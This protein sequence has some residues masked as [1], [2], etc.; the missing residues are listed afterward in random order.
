MALP[1]VANRS[2]QAVTTPPPGVQKAADQFSKLAQQASRS[3][4]SANTT[5]SDGKNTGIKHDQSKV[6][7]RGERDQGG[8]GDQRDNHG[9]QRRIVNGVM[10]TT[11]GD[12]HVTRRRLGTDEPQVPAGPQNAGVKRPEIKQEVGLT[13]GYEQLR[14][15][16]QAFPTAGSVVFGLP[17][18]FD[19]RINPR[20]SETTSRTAS[21]ASSTGATYLQNSEA[22]ASGGDSSGGDGGRDG[23]QDGGDT[24]GD[25][26]GG[27]GGTI[28]PNGLAGG[29]DGPDGIDFEMLQKEV[30]QA[31][32]RE[33]S[34]LGL[35]AITSSQN[36]SAESGVQSALRQFFS[37]NPGAKIGAA[38][39]NSLNNIASMLPADGDTAETMLSFLRQL[40]ENN[41]KNKDWLESDLLRV[42]TSTEKL[43]QKQDPANRNADSLVGIANSLTA[44]PMT[45]PRLREISET[46]RSPDFSVPAFGN[47]A[48]INTFVDQIP[49]STGGDESYANAVASGAGQP[50]LDA[51]MRSMIKHFFGETPGAEFAGKILD[52]IF[53]LATTQPYNPAGSQAMLSMLRNIRENGTEKMYGLSSE[54]LSTIISIAEFFLAQLGSGQHRN[55]TVLDVLKDMAEQYN[56]DSEPEWLANMASQI[57]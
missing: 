43:V 46:L 47:P 44:P 14:N 33:R 13:A 6:Q 25:N 10:I 20:L 23:G 18:I 42:L 40:L 26:S 56:S 30:Q 41:N 49:K 12:G 34:A 7:S 55:R 57:G 31:T 1:P 19:T 35:D 29:A 53:S 52:T 3:S 16:G 50:T 37:E 45:P 39:V 24:S 15:P 51:A 36:A 48:D 9:S 22:T 4:E 21:D 27:G 8:Q 54:M 11:S 2:P 5:G 38:E 17:R 28:G 32:I